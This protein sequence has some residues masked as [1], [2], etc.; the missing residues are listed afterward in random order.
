MK[1]PVFTLLVFL[2]II[3]FRHEDFII[4]LINLITSSTIIIDKDNVVHH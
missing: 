2:I 1:R 4:H 3:I